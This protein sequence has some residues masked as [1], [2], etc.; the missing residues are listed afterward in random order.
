MRNLMLISAK[1]AG[2]VSA[3]ML[4]MSVQ[5]QDCRQIADTA[6]R[7]EC[8]DRGGAKESQQLTPQ[9]IEIQEAVRRSLKDPASALF[10]PLAMYNTEFGCQTVN[11]RNAFGGYTGNQQAFVTK[12]GGKWVTLDVKDLTAQQCMEV[13][14]KMKK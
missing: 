14:Q 4:C 8:Y 10:G 13:L 3:A 11:G 1:T 6:K 9:E 2:L 7:L 5:A 12:L